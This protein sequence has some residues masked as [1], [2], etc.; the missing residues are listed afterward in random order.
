VNIGD[1]GDSGGTGLSLS[2][3]DVVS[4]LEFAAA[5]DAT[6]QVAGASVRSLATAVNTPPSTIGGWVN[7]RHLPNV[8]QVTLLLSVLEHLGVGKA[9][10]SEW[11]TALHR[12]RLVPGPRPNDTEAPYRGLEPFAE[13]D[14]EWFFG[15]DVL[16]DA[17]ISRLSAVTST[18]GSPQLI[19]LVGGSGTGKS[20]FL[21][22]GLLPRVSAGAVPGFPNG[23]YLTPGVD[24][25]G[26]LEQVRALQ[27]SATLIIVDRMEELFTLGS[28]P[29][30]CEDFVNSLAHAARRQ[31]VIIA[32]RSDFYGQL[33]EFPSLASALENSQILIPPLTTK[34]LERV[35]VEPAKRSG[36]EV[37][38]A[39]VERLLRDFSSGDAGGSRRSTL[40]LLAH[41]L[42]E[43]WNRRR[44]GVMSLTDYLDAGG[45]EGA[46]E[47]TAENS[48]GELDADEQ[49]TAHTLFL[50]LVNLNS[51][52]VTTRRALKQKDV[53]SNGTE[54]QSAREA[55]VVD[56]FV[57]HRLLSVHD[58]D[59]EIAHEVLLS[60]W[61]RLRQWIDADRE[62]LLI[63]SRLRE[64]IRAWSENPHD[65]STLV[66]GARLDQLTDW[67][68]AN[69]DRS[70]LTTAEQNYLAASTTHRLALERGQRRR[71]R[72]LWSL[73]TTAAALAVLASGVAV[74][75]VKQRNQAQSQRNQAQEATR[76][77]SSRRLALESRRAT[78]RDPGV[79]AQLAALAYREQPTDDAYGALI[80]AT[81]FPIPQR[82]VGAQGSTPLAI[83][84]AAGLAAAP[85]AKDGS[86]KVFDI[87]GALARP[88][89]TIPPIDGAVDYYSTAI[90]ADGSWLAA[91]GANGGVALWSLAANAGQLVDAKLG[92]FGISVQS[93]VISSDG[94]QLIAAGSSAD[95]QRWTLT[96]GSAP[97]PVAPIKVPLAAD[98]T[99]VLKAVAL[100]A[101]NSLVAA[102][103]DDG[104]V[105]LWRNTSSAESFGELPGK[106]DGGQVH[107]IAFDPV[108]NRMAIG[109]RGGEVRIV[110]ISPT[111]AM[112]DADGVSLKLGGWVNTLAF[113]ADGSSLA[114]GGSDSDV[115]VWRTSDWVRQRVLSTPSPVVGVGFDRDGVNVLSTSNDGVL[116]RWPLQGA[117]LV[118]PKAKIFSVSFDESGNRMAVFPGTSD[119]TVELWDTSKP[120]AVNP[121]DVRI[122]PGDPAVKLSGSGAINRK[123]TTL[124][125]GTVDGQL[126]VWQATDGKIRALPLIPG[127][128]SLIETVAAGPLDLFA[129]AA[130]DGSIP[131][132]D[133]ADLN[134]P[135]LRTKLADATGLMLGVAFNSDGTLIAGANADHSVYLWD[136]HNL[137]A[138]KL[139]SRLTGFENYAYSA[140]FSDDGKLLATG[141]AEGT[142]QVWD[143]STPATPKKVGSPI[144]G[145]QN[146]VYSLAFKKG[147]R[148]LAA[149][150]TDHTVWLWDL[151]KPEEPA[152]V[153][154]LDSPKSAIF[155]AAFQ[156]GTNILAAGGAD[157]TIF[158]WNLD[159][160]SALHT[161]C[162]Y[163]GDFLSP[164]EWRRFLPDRPYSDECAGLRN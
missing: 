75:A 57:G 8:R 93:L 152:H 35:I 52:G 148:L 49:A 155:T 3:R 132:W 112:A 99:I 139:L 146:Y 18:N 118:G 95:I 65:Q 20:S 110:N 114:A 123:G 31:P 147:E 137:D 130:D 12:V 66:G 67:V 160:K 25:V 100:S 72:V 83:S 87:G 38:P 144:I 74:Y 143:I 85:N 13:T 90:S 33:C 80:D 4:R 164:A 96:R 127:A 61:P 32:T 71:R 142:V 145:P 39:L 82:L 56:H 30:F 102:G 10:Q 122:A 117:P 158:R 84:G 125:S 113:S 105:R 11:V 1:N 45:L 161:A 124:A 163:S 64:P 9:E 60:A 149:G 78:E 107:A 69:G 156:P 51:E 47:Q 104:T 86:I 46:V 129:A 140:A 24:P 97:S 108:A 70:V 92:D 162:T 50:K 79:A 109:Y 77:A 23:A 36:V 159:P 37:E 28:S 134:N 103:G 29:T 121:I 21:R 115:S 34:D 27:E 89:F 153:A 40:P 133:L 111:G 157:L 43:T 126:Q 6:R 26:T 58:D 88:K 135:K 106:K 44:R 5:L 141:S 94:Q 63:L 91:G 120:N 53:G 19:A 7:G 15:R 41:A 150:V 119:G 131:I 151:T 136:I 128:T 98:K 54:E 76:V 42:L 62:G 81:A 55:R 48:Y 59:V 16:A 138:P 101:D 73:G 154:T 68:A 2:I 116:R 14:S 17:V 22:A